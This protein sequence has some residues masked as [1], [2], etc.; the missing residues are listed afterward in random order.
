MKTT[1]QQ[2]KDIDARIWTEH[3]KRCEALKAVQAS[4]SKDEVSALIGR[5]MDKTRRAGRLMDLR[6]RLIIQLEKEY[7]KA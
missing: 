1:I 5:L 4:Q 7:C 6:E 2:I 3:G